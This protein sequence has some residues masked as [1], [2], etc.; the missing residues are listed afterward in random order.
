[1]NQFASVSALYHGSV[2]TLIG[3]RS[4]NQD[5][6][7]YAETPLGYLVV[8]CDGMG[9]GPG[10]RTASYI[11]VSRF[12]QAVH[13]ANSMASPEEVLKRAVALTQEALVT[14]MNANPALRGMGSTLVAVLF[15]LQAAWVVH[16]G[17]SRCYRM[18]HGKM[19][20]R[21]EDHSLVGELVQHGTITEEQA[22]KS[23]Q[24]NIITRGLGSLSNNTPTIDEVPYQRGDRFFLCTDGVWGI[25]PQPNLLHRF[26]SVQDTASLVERIQTEVDQL[27]AAHGGGHDNHTLA[28]VQ[29]ECASKLKDKMDRIS[30]IIIAVLAVCLLVSLAFNFFGGGASKGENTREISGNQEDFSLQ[31]ENQQLKEQIELL[32]RQMNEL[33]NSGRN[34]ESGDEVNK[35]SDQVPIRDKQL[36]PD[37]NDENKDK[38]DEHAESGKPGDS[39]SDKAIEDIAIR[40][41]EDLKLDLDSLAKID[42][43]NQGLAERKHKNRL[44]KLETGIDSLNQV[45]GN[46]FND[47]IDKFKKALKLIAKPKRDKEQ[48]YTHAESKESIDNLRICVDVIEKKYKEN[49]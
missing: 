15:T 31:L 41:L 46:K 40:I 22:R 27:G 35:S 32:Q 11:A 25:M 3:G 17:D 47:E 2:D 1:M 16:T 5:N 36:L 48:H 44:N 39:K 26:A 10:G 9:G 12:M 45:T 49:K 38:S 6:F 29:V 13:E 37:R 24:S 7:G 4:E 43:I 20:F 30:K 42:C 28:I 8:V 23:P 14:E 34:T 19:R 18:S 33:K 21:T